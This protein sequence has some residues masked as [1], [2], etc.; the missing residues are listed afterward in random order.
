[1]GPSV[2]ITNFL[3]FYRP[4]SGLYAHL[5]MEVVR[6]MESNLAKEGK[7]TMSM[8]PDREAPPDLIYHDAV[9]PDDKYYYKDIVIRYNFFFLCRRHYNTFRI[10]ICMEITQIHKNLITCEK[11]ELKL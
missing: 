11:F 8:S 3:L 5:M 1:M 6:S 4:F 2:I 9:T 7:V 10:Q